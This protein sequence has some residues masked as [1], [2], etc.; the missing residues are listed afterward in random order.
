MKKPSKCY[1]CYG[2]CYCEYTH[3]HLILVIK[4]NL[5]EYVMDFEKNWT[6]TTHNKQLQNPS[7]ISN[8]SKSL[9][10]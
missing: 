10:S 5:S 7:Y 4:K 9:I 8:F 3:L 2:K 1:T 6:I